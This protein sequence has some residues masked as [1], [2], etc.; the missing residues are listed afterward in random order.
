MNG[1]MNTGATSFNISV[2]DLNQGA[3]S[4]YISISGFRE[5]KGWV[6]SGPEDKPKSLRKTSFWCCVQ[7]LSQKRVADNSGLSSDM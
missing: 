2:S 3:M 1:Q 4:P 5:T 6:S 7:N